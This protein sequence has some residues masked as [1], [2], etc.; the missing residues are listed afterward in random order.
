M[1]V[2]HL[3]T[4]MG[5]RGGE[6]QLRLLLEG[7][8]AYP[9][10][11]HLAA[12][13]G[14]EAARRL[15]GLAT[16]VTY[17]MRGGFD[18]VAAYKI[19]TYCKKNQIDL[20]DAHT[21][22]GHS[23]GLLVKTL[24]PN[25]KLIVHRRVDNVP[26]NNALN[27]R[28]YLSPRVDLYVAISGAIAK[29]LENYGVP[30][31]RIALV[32]SAVPD[33]VYQDLNRE[34]EKRQLA[35][36]FG[37]SPDVVFIGNASALSSQKGYPTLLAAAKILKDQGKSFHVFIAGDGELRPSL[38]SLRISLGLE[39]DVTFLGFI[40]EVPKFLCAMDILAMP[41][42]NEGLGTLLL[43]ASLA[44]CAIAATRVGGIPEVVTHRITGLLSSVDDSPGL[45]AHLAQL[46]QEPALRHHLG[47]NARDFVVREFA[48]EAMVRGNFTIYSTLLN[49]K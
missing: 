3:D 5:W 20:I 6:N 10:E 27:R 36:A 47:T 34:N 18:P 17:P 24:V 12:R 43:D 40:K 11:S 32:R 22:N 7:L 41:S 48:W 8:R 46:I 39:H 37:I 28:K 25:V 33:I 29:I 4:E 38:E 13:P 49:P 16:V 9:V 42:V 21:G 2:L 26:K 30:K 31:E 45:A 35:Q 1:R 15:D 23:L 44:R 19:A 14:S